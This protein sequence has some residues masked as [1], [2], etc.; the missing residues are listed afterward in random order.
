MLGWLPV[1]SAATVA[2]AGVVGV[3]AESATG[4]GPHIQKGEEIVNG[5]RRWLRRNPSASQHYRLARA[6]MMSWSTWWYV[7]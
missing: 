4:G 7:P 2:R 5:L 6:S 1:T 3:Y